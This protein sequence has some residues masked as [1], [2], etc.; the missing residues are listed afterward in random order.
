MAACAPT[1]TAAPV[2]VAS[3]V[4]EPLEA[5]ESP[6][7]FAPLGLWL[8]APAEAIDARYTI[9]EGR[10]AQVQFTLDDRHYTYRSARSEVGISEVHANFDPT[11]VDI[12]ACGTTLSRDVSFRQ[13]ERGTKGALAVWTHGAADYT[14]QTPD[15]I[16]SESFQRLGMDLALHSAEAC[17]AASAAFTCS[18]D[19]HGQGF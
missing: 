15:A 18:R 4:P 2:P 3:A 16:V 19:P 14:L 11:I 7:A 17:F 5:V 8:E 10:T 6:A 13:I 12:I 9:L 1:T